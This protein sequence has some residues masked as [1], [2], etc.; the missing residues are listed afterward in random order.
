MEENPF[1]TCGSFFW[2]SYFFPGEEK[3]KEGRMGKKQNQ[4]IKRI[5]QR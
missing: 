4:N 5:K 3:L 2:K 1:L